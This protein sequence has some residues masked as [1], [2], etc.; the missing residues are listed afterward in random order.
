MF[1]PK[2][3]QIEKQDRNK[4]DFCKYYVYFV[5]KLLIE[6]KQRNLSVM[7]YYTS[8]FLL[9][10]PQVAR[11]SSSLVLSTF[12]WS[13]NAAVLKQRAPSFVYVN[14]FQ[15]K[16][17]ISPKCVSAFSLSFP[18]ECAYMIPIS[19]LV[20]R[21]WVMKR[22]AT[23]AKL[24]YSSNIETKFQFSSLNQITCGLNVMFWF[25]KVEFIRSWILLRYLL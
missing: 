8:S 15:W 7:V 6:N 12:L 18:S 22:Y 21:V 19:L 1:L 3:I 13:A 17:S 5:T 24:V 16:I 2:G 20:A 10:Q 4:V 11:N 9:L 23:K 25:D 14:F